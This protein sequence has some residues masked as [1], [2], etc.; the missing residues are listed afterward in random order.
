MKINNQLLPFRNFDGPLL[1]IPVPEF[2][3]T[4]RVSGILGYNK[5]AAIEVQQTLPLK[6]TLLGLEYKVAV[7]QGT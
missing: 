7:N 2:T 1:D 5:E 3:G 6:M 4:K